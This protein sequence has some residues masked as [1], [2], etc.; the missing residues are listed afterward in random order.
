MIEFLPNLVTLFKSLEIFMKI[1]NLLPILLSAFSLNTTAFFN[2]NGFSS[3]GNNSPYNNL[4]PW[5]NNQNWSP[6]SANGQY[7]PVKNIRNIN[8]FDDNYRSLQNYRQ[9]PMANNRVP[10]ANLIQPSSW[11]MDTDFSKTLEQ[12]K[13]PDSKTFFVNEIPI[14]FKAD[15][16]QIQKQSKGIQ[17]IVKTPMSAYSDTDNIYGKQ[18]YGLSP[19]A[20]STTRVEIK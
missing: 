17:Q 15:Y 5:G 7:Y 8:R 19:A 11:L 10:K 4:I 14:N 20:S 9:N 18:G 3:F 13:K 6:M 12:V 1:T 2:T 16:Q